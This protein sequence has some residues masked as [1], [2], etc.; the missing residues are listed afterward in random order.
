MSL[1]SDLGFRRYYGRPLHRSTHSG[2]VLVGH[3]PPAVVFLLVDPAVMVEGLGYEGGMR[4]NDGRKRHTSSLPGRAG[5][6]GLDRMR[7]GRTAVAGHPDVLLVHAAIEVTTPPVFL[8]EGVEGGEQVR[9][10][11]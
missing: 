4:E 6:R 7:D 2:P 11:T 10:G 8:Q 3:Y 5:L 9:H 1:L